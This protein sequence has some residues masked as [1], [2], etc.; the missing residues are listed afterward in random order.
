MIFPCFELLPFAETDRAGQPLSRRQGA[1]LT[2]DDHLHSLL[3]QRFL[4]TLDGL[5]LVEGIDHREVPDPHTAHDRFDIDP[6]RSLGLELFIRAGI[7]LEAGHARPAV[8]Q[9]DHQDIRAVLYRVDQGWN[10]GVE[11]CRVPDGGDQWMFDAGSEKPLGQAD[12]GT[13]RHLRPA[14]VERRIHA[15][16]R[17]ADVSGHHRVVLVQPDLFQRPVDGHEASPVGTAG[18]KGDRVLDAELLLGYGGLLSPSLLLSS[19]PLAR[20]VGIVRFGSTLACSCSRAGN[21]SCFGALQG[22]QAC[23]DDLLAVLACARQQAVELAQ[24]GALP[25][26]P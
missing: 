12:A 16:D 25:A 8:V 17:T 18:A 1:L 9:D 6:A 15:Q 5:F 23:G 2:G 13:H 24:D 21:R 3:L 14:G 7:D 22:L 19:G 11:K 4:D 26:A 20:R 10:P